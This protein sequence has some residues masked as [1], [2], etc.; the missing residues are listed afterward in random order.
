M[1]DN[2]YVVKSVLVAALV[3]AAGACGSKSKKSGPTTPV[4]SSETMKET[5]DLKIPKIDKS[6]CDTKGKRE[7]S[8]DLNGDDSPDVWKLYATVDKHEVLTC[9]QVD[10][11]H[12]G[13]K[14]YVATYDDLGNLVAEEYDFDYDGTFD[15]KVHYDKKTHKKF[16]VERETGY[17]RKPDVWEKYDGSE[18]LESVRRDQNLDGK[19]D[20]WEHY[21]SGVLEKIQWDDDFDGIV[22]RQEEIKSTAA[23]PAAALPPPV[24]APTETPP[25]PADAKD[26]PAEPTKDKPATKDKAKSK[27]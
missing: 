19:P 7:D 20:T 22:D 27:T 25:K 9:K 2:T 6:L 26:K 23:P 14:D 18:L 4:G 17:D 15:A 13:K 8:F 11:D 24:E 12:N 21:R 10:L 16:L 5:E 1:R 3:I